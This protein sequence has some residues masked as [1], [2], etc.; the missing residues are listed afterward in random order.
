[1]EW[2]FDLSSKPERLLWARLS[3]F[4]GTFELDAVEGVCT[5]EDLSA[6]D[7][8]ETL[9][10]L[11]DKSIVD[12][13][14]SRDG[15][16]AQARY[17]MLEVIRDFGQEQLIESGERSKLCDR[18]RDWYQRLAARAATERIS[19]RQTYW[20]ARFTREH[21]NVRA[22]VE[23]CL[24]EPGHADDAL[25]IVTGLPWLYWWS[26]G[27]CGEELGW[28]ERALART[29][30]PTVLRVRAL[31]LAGFLAGWLDDTDAA[32]SWV[33]EGECLAERLGDATGTAL[34]AFVR[35]SAV[36][37]QCDD[38]SGVIAS[39]ERGLAV[40][41]ALPER[42][43]H[44]ELTLRLQLLLQL[45]PAAALAGQYDRA[46]RCFEETLEI[47]EAAGAGLNRTWALWGLGLVAWR[48]G[49]VSTADKHVRECLRSAREAGVP[50][51]YLAALGI[52]MLAWIAAGQRQRQRAATLLGAVDRVQSDLGRSVT[53]YRLMIADHDGCDRQV[54]AALGDAAFTGAFWHG[55]TLALDDAL[56]YALDGRRATTPPTGS[57]A[58]LT[59]RELEVARLIVRGMSNKDIATRL[60][61][62][63]RT[64]ESH[65]EHIL[66]KLGFTSRAQI[67]AWAAEEHP[68]TPPG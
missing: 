68:T 2:S 4:V 39:A 7:L 47:A 13:V 11:I 36:L 23:F 37:R 19:R 9:A 20:I 40:V 10:G 22:A 49:H 44:R 6:E 34:A 5:D 18:H 60:V 32:L 25:R 56:A 59:R 12:R 53:G 58:P 64:A 46:R 67:A 43:R 63:Q 65:V 51:A 55:Q 28:L 24:I 54:R 16:G 14:D 57:A 31:L 62:A 8:L 30:M 50:D 3:V 48:E 66:V 52:A 21:P 27:V 17:R 35:G 1:V 41:S 42:E 45:G 29:T 26:R 33:A 15:A 61:V 38:P